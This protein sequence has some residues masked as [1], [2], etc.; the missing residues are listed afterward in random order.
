MLRRVPMACL[1][2]VVLAA[3][4]STAQGQVAAQVAAT[5]NGQ[6]IDVA[7]VE[8]KLA[9]TYG[10]VAKISKE[11]L[12]RFQ[13]TALQQLID[14]QLVLG[15]LQRTKG[16]AGDDEVK[17]SLDDLQK[18]LEANRL[19][20]A[21]FV[22]SKGHT[23]E[24][25]RKEVAWQLN[26]NRYTARHL[27]D[28]ALE[29]YFERHRRE[30][31]GTELRVSHILLKPAEPAT[32]D[33]TKAVMEQASQIRQQIVDGKLTFEEAVAKFSAGTKKDGGDL[34]YIRRQAPMTEAFSRAAFR[35][36]RGEISPPVASII[37]IH[38][39][40][41][42]DIKPG[43]KTLADDA[44]RQRVDVLLKQQHFETIAAKERK[45][46]RVEFTGKCPY[47]KPDTGQLVVDD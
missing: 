2:F 32:A 26:W 15:H 38:L 9:R 33:Q 46:A 34:G 25:Y 28:K 8:R 45:T 37:G 20:L 12:P 7:D 1:L 10:N 14:Q 35:L 22:K 31:D 43:K 30:L 18:R 23:L 11:A 5:V 17:I 39:I 41:C 29:E 13:A 21:D 6:A 19:S 4:F 36:N 24:S 40:R 16:A 47:L 44:V 42:T 3:S 27:T